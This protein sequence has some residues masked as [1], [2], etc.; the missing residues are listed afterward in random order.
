M[1]PTQRPLTFSLAMMIAKETAYN[2]GDTG[3]IGLIPRSGRSPGGGHGNPPQ[4]SCLENPKDRG[5][6]RAIVHRSQSQIQMK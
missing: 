5:D 3:D 1:Y 6:W 4:Y 2:E